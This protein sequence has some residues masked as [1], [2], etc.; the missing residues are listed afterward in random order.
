MN[1]KPIF[2]PKPIKRLS[3]FGFREPAN[4]NQ[5][6]GDFFQRTG[7][8][9]PPPQ[10]PQKSKFAWKDW[11]ISAIAWKIQSKRRQRE[12]NYLIKSFQAEISPAT[13]DLD[14]MQ[15]TVEDL[16]K[17]SEQRQKTDF[18]APNGIRVCWKPWILFWLKNASENQCRGR[19][20]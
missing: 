16:K 19:K 18:S 13:A 2:I 12:R 11:S 10:T 7:I 1:T 5:L 3:N 4:F 17:Q 14:A 9:A 20:R 8:F 15:K 6:Q